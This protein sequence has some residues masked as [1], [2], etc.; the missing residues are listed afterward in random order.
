MNIINRLARLFAVLLLLLSLLSDFL[1][2]SAPDLQDL[3]QFYAPPSRIHLLDAQ[4]NFHWRPFVHRMKLTDAL[5]ARYQVQGDE[6]YPLE[7]FCQGYRYRFLGLIPASTHLVGTRTAGMFHPWGTDAQGRDVLAQTLAGT[8]SSM[9][10]LLFGIALYFA[11][12]VTIGACAGMA[13]SWIDVVL[14]RFSEFVLALP[15]LYLVVAVRALLPPQMPFWQTALLTAATI[16]GVTWPPMARGVRGLILQV[17]NAGYV[18]AA[19]ALGASPWYIFRRHM[20]PALAP[21]AMAQIAVAAPVFILGEVILSFLNVG[22]QNSWASWGAMLRNLTQDPRV[23]TDF[24][25]NL[26]PLGFVFV[27]LFCLNSFGRRLRAKEPTQL[28]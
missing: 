4:G 3:N 19:R 9:L 23:L 25:W 8:R 11:L 15:A 10:V 14:M 17:R 1:S 16:A 6:V 13:G 18:E 20:L 28:A 24:W 26:S 7:F 27:T 12:G 22:F 21:F 2:P 5:D